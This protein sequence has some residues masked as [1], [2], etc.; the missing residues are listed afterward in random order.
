MV[1]LSMKIIQ[2]KYSGSA[3]EPASES[4]ARAALSPGQGK[5]PP[6]P[7]ANLNFKLNRR[8]LA[9]AIMIA[10]GPPSYST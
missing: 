1:N 2:H 6:S 9:L 10:S 8:P 4:G 7:S 5:E 3:S